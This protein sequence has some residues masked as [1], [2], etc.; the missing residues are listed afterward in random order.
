M[1]SSTVLVPTGH[2]V[3]MI[4]FSKALPGDCL[5]EKMVQEMKRRMQVFTLDAKKQI[6]RS[7]VPPNDKTVYWLPVDAQGNV[8][9][10]LQSYDPGSGTWIEV[11]AIGQCISQE[12]GNLLK[13][14]GEGCLL[15][16][17]GNVPGYVEITPANL[18]PSSGTAT[19]AIAYTGMSDQTAQIT[20]EF[21]GDPGPEA[22]W[23]TT[24]KINTG[25]NVQ[26][27]GL[28]GNVSCLIY[29]RRST[30]T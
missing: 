1:N 10:V 29:A 28:G 4:V 8:I 5:S 12:A 9:G 23:W 19:K 27:A 22:R 6:V 18:A 7:V 20:V 30:Q 24:D 3:A 2:N 13:A 25:C 17:V 26:F 16:A 21:T 14:D 15:V 11:S